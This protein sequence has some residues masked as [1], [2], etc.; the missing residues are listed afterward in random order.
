MITFTKFQ[1][2]IFYYLKYATFKYLD[3]SHQLVLAPSVS[4]KK[5]FE[6]CF[7]S[8]GSVPFSLQ[9]LLGTFCRHLDVPVGLSKTGVPLKDTPMQSASHLRLCRKVVLTF[10][11][12]ILHLSL[13]LLE[14]H[15]YQLLVF[16]V[17]LIMEIH[18]KSWQSL[19]CDKVDLTLAFSRVL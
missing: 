9:I 14:V 12:D 2:P 1:S 4:S 11:L 7:C 13:V 18:S 17:A 8:E 5:N 15:I 16:I 10:L 6:L 3:I 19:Q